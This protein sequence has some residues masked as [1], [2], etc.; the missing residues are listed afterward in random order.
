MDINF[1]EG[2]IKIKDY[3]I[4]SPEYNFEKFKAS[5]LYNGQDE[6]RF[7]WLEKAY[8][9]D[10]RKWKIGLIFIKQK[11]Y[12]VTLTCIEQNFSA[13]DEPKRKEFHNEIL[14]KYG[15]NE[16]RIFNWGKVSSIYDERSNV[17]SILIKYNL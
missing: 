11:I 12:G 9:L 5:K 8:V 7:M 17:S 15:I 16:E 10:D 1:E 14:K 3:L 13:I 4:I 2:I 6:T